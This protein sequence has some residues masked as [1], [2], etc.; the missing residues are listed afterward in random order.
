MWLF[1]NRHVHCSCNYLHV[2]LITLLCK[3]YI[4]S[5]G[6]WTVA[7]RCCLLLRPFFFRSSPTSTEQSCLGLTSNRSAVNCGGEQ[8]CFWSVAI[9]S[10]YETR[11]RFSPTVK[12]I[13]ARMSCTLLRTARGF[14]R[15]SVLP[16]RFWTGALLTLVWLVCA[17]HGQYCPPEC[18]CD[19]K[20]NG[21]SHVDCSSRELLR[22][23]NFYN[24]SG[25]IEDL[26]V[27]NYT[28]V[29]SGFA[30]RHSYDLSIVLML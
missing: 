2:F 9:D 25:D 21:K 10:I 13:P 18:T 15:R 27:Y 19:V 4:C 3:P 17:V 28:H 7:N 11:R 6:V 30:H 23:P 26:W 8:A 29:R 20:T 16:L 12:W 5:V 22:V 1:W 14:G 24:L